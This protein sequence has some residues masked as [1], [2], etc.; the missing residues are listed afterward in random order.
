MSPKKLAPVLADILIILSHPREGGG[1]FKNICIQNLAAILRHFP[2]FLFLEC[3][4]EM[5]FPAKNPPPP[6]VNQRP[7]RSGLQ[8]STQI[9]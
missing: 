2:S 3:F 5:S 8:G 9:N 7:E 1:I 6:I 4:R